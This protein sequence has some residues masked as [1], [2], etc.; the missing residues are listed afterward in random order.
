MKTSILL[1]VLASVPLLRCRPARA[2]EAGEPGLPQLAQELFLAETVYPQERGQVQLTA[3]SRFRSG[4]HTRL[5]GE[6]GFTDRFQASVLTP[7]LEGDAEED[8]EPWE[9]GVMY[10]LLPGGSPLALSVSLEASLADGEAAEW[11]PSLIAAKQW[12]RVQ[13]HGSVAAGLAEPARSVTGTAAALLD[14][15][16]L[17]P[18]LELTWSADDEEYAVPG[19]FFRP[20]E[21]VELG[22]GVPVCVS[23]GSSPRQLRAM[24]TVEL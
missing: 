15:G 20:R 17:T 8:E 16:R 5:L 21:G 12:G 11:E 13:L 6:Y 22:V 18:T 1:L 14:A 24:V 19:A 23:C 4:P 9:L 10:A 3:H 7:A 2:Q